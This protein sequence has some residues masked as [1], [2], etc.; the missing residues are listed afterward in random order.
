MTGKMYS[1]GMGRAGLVLNF[2]GVNVTFFPLFLI[3]IDGMPRRYYDY[4]MFPEFE[5][6]QQLAT[7][8]AFLVA[9]G[10]TIVIVSWIHGAIWGEK[11]PDNPWGSKSMEWTHTATPPGAGN[12]PTPPT[13][14]AS[15][16][17]YNYGK[18]TA[19]TI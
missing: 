17:P 5:G 3:G 7:V 14:D 6:A 1:E 8:G 2:I 16:S 19:Q 12:F 4:Q 10:M 11:A 18:H 13:V 9:I 15:W